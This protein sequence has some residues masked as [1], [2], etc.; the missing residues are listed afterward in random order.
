MIREKR[1]VSVGVVIA[2]AGKGMRMGSHEKKQFIL[3]QGKPVLYH[4]VSIFA[5][6]PEVEKIVV[7]SAAQDLKRTSNLLQSFPQVEVVS[8]GAE[9]QQSVLAGL[10]ALGSIEFVLIHDAARPFTSERLI[11]Q[12]IIA[13]QESDAV[14]LA[15]PVKDTIKTVDE[16]GYILSTPPRQSLWAAQTPQAFRLSTIADA[17]QQASRQGFIGTDDAM[18][19]EW[20]QYPVKIIPG[21]YTN[22]K[23]TTREDLDQAESILSRRERGDANV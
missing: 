9:R 6:I 21:E 17:H 15:V 16:S 7:V 10:A 4:S 11:H 19:L 1:T 13:V 20:L 23:L 2:A 14:I 18:V 3:L 5:N 12:L 8:G 22:I